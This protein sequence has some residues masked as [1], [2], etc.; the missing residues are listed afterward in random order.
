MVVSAVEGTQPM[1][2]DLHTQVWTSIDQLGREAAERV[3]NR[4]LERWGQF[5]GSPA[6]HERA[7]HCV[8]GAVV[9]GFRSELLSA[10][11]PNEYIAGFVNEDPPYE[12]P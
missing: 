5:D 12:P 4:R 6:S 3:R 9:L 8:D 10:R 1:I 2:V 7:M 11:I